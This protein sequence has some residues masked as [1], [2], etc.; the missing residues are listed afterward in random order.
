MKNSHSLKVKQRFILKMKPWKISWKQNLGSCLQLY[1]GSHKTISPKNYLNFTLI[2]FK[3]YTGNS[4]LCFNF[5]VILL[6]CTIISFIKL[7][8]LLGIDITKNNP[9][10]FPH[11]KKNIVTLLNIFFCKSNVI[12]KIMLR[13]FAHI[14]LYWH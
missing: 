13:Q 9:S 5:L 7:I 6:F 2:I 11:Q 3:L 8:F 12:C 14:K 10:A 4:Q 1:I